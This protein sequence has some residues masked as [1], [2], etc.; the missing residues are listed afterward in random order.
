MKIFIIGDYSGSTK[1]E[2]NQNVL[3]AQKAAKEIILKGHLPI[4][5]QSM[6]AVMEDFTAMDKIMESC[7]DWIKECDAV[8]VLSKGSETGNKSKALKLAELNNKIIFDSIHEI[9][10]DKK[11][12]E[13]DLN[14]I[15]ED[16][17]EKVKIGSVYQ[18]YKSV[19]YQYKVEDIVISES[20]QQPMIIYSALY[21]DS[22]PKF[23]RPIS[24]FLA[25]IEKNGELLDRFK[26]V[27]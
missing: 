3:T 12:T 25:K 15:L 9:K 11:L 21:W 10:E 7:F 4:I 23:S 27:I 14:S 18:H 1:E 17:K 8:L 16:T 6:Y 2:I 26:L 19:D 22:K 13:E 24:S 5:P 20:S